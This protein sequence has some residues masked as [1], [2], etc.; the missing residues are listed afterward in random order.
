MA[1]WESTQHTIGDILDWRGAKRITLTPDF[2]RREVWSQAAK[3]MLIDSIL[4][5]IPL[6]KFFV[7]R[8]VSGNSTF[9]KVID[10]Q[11]RL[12]AI[13]EFIDGEFKLKSAPCED[14][15]NNKKFSD[16]DKSAQDKI[17]NYRIDINEITDAED[18]EVRSI[19]SRVNK[20]V[21]QLNKQ[22]LRKADFPGS[23]LD[24]CE[25][26]VLDERLDSFNLFTAA[27]RRRMGDV[28]FVSEL[29]ALMLGN[30]PL[31]KKEELDFFYENYSLWDEDSKNTAIKEFNQ[32]IDDCL[33]I[34]PGDCL[35]SDSYALVL[36]R[37]S[38]SSESLEH[39]SKTRFRQKA[40]FYALF[41]AI[42][43][44]HQQGGCLAGKDLKPL[45]TDL[46]LLDREIEP[47]SAYPILSEYAI[48]CL[49][50]AN[51]ASSRRWRIDFLENILQG[52]YLNSITNNGISIFYSI[53]YCQEYLRDYSFCPPPEITCPISEEEFTPS[54]DNSVIG[55]TQGT[56]TLQMANSYFIRR[57]SLQ[58]DTKYKWKIIYPPS[59]RLDDENYHQTD[60]ELST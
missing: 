55:W 22:E 14:I 43:K 13:F 23:F 48:R 19:Y 45:R 3:I 16:L 59:N 32:I 60:L 47:S 49:S 58:D 42:R 10:G 54:P 37:D 15:F 9:R 21:V 40:D 20:Y 50:D 52:T 2:Q 53:L 28:E 26:L 56:D 24:T 39:I 33:N 46:L 29:L 51:S 36:R 1:T 17:I 27:N 31:D 41:G 8:E 12:K 5:N 18:E 7:T 35:N 4:K 57:D 30:K 25:Q 44:L 38:E 34:F 6:P 11:Q